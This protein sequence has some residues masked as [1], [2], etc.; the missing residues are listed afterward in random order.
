MKTTN[1][2]TI[3]ESWEEYPWDN[4]RWP[5]FKPYEFDCKG[6]GRIALD[7]NSLDKL[8]TLRSRINRPFVIVSGYRSP[9]HNRAV[10]GARNSFHMQGIA[11]DVSLRGLDKEE[12]FQKAEEAG[13]DGIGKY[14]TF[15]HIDTRGYKARWG[16][17]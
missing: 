9:E 8:Q 13:F 5:N 10:G 15:I 17:W 4:K 2:L 12:M 3:Y 16:N 7:P 14:N 11:F 1:G 6:T